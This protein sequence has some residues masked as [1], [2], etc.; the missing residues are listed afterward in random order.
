MQGGVFV[1]VAGTR[2][3]GHQYISK[4]IEMGASAVICERIPENTVQDIVYVK[5]R[6]SAY[7]LGQIASNYFD[8]PSSRLKLIGV[9]GTNGKTTTASLLYNVFKGLGYKTGLFSTVCNRLDDEVLPATH[10]TPDPVKLNELLARMVEQNCTHCCMEV[11]SHAVVQN[12]IAGIEFAGGIFT[13][14]THD[15]L[16]YHKTFDNYI[17]AKK[18]FFDSLPASSFAL[19]NIDDKHGNIMVQNTKAHVHTY[20][21]TNIADFRCSVLENQFSGLHLNMD[22]TEVW[23]QLA[24]IFNAYNLLAI[25]AAA[26]LLGE[27]K[28]KVLTVLSSCKAV[29]GRFDTI[30]GPKNITAIIDYAHTPD[31][32]KNILSTIVNIH[33]GKGQ[34]ITVIG[35]GG[36][37]DA[38][39]RP[40]MARIAA[41]YS[42][43]VILTSDNP[44]SEDPEQII[45]EMKKGVDAT[46]AR[47]V[48]SV[49]NRKEAIRTA[50][51][52]AKAGDIILVAGKGHEKYQ[53]IKGEKHP[54]DDKEIVRDIL[55]ETY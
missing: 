2:T 53:E 26:V 34:I 39:K 18:G 42:N 29:E 20:S 30:H 21:L 37:R 10:T 49:V 14:I 9:T 45:S 1:A 17:S 46:G 44:R 52:L 50:C 27:E 48:L 31:A 25:Y 8:N 6:D 3:D 12:R 22:G 33:E 7:A 23:F 38:A 43:R 24:G 4:A 19:V 11:S 51:A 15:H 13:N 47:K 32:L 35:A 40:I 55:F 41:E 16:D 5:V 54:F 28:T 36:D